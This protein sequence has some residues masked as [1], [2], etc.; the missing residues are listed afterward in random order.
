MTE[1]QLRGVWLNKHIREM[2]AERDGTEG[3]GGE[4]DVGMGIGGERK[5]DD[6]VEKKWKGARREGLGSREM[7][8]EMGGD[9]RR[10]VTSRELSGEMGGDTLV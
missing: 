5:E 4:G 3:M 10:G 9:T 6:D 2:I 8:G 7:S 1:Q